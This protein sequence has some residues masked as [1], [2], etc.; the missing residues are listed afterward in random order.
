MEEIH[1]NDNLVLG[2]AVTEAINDLNKEKRELEE[3]IEL[4]KNLEVKSLTEE[5]WHKICETPLRH[6]DVLSVFIQ[7]MFEGATDIQV[8]ANIVRF[9][10]KDFIIDIP[11]SL[12]RGITVD[13]SWYV[14]IDKMEENIEDLK[15]TEW[16]NL[17]IHMSTN[18]R[19]VYQ[20]KEYL[21]KKSEG[22]NW[23]TLFDIIYFNQKEFKLSNLQQRILWWYD[24]KVAPIDDKYWE[25]YIQNYE[26]EVEKSIK[27]QEQRIKECYDKLD[28]FF[29]EIYPKL[30]EFTD[31]IEFR[32]VFYQYRKGLRKQIDNH[33]ISMMKY[34]RSNF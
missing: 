15:N 14:D 8:G 23:K 34:I 9:N 16:R 22:A 19:E 29:Y 11:T 28:K 4:L 32:D 17:D 21:E 30:R 6:N 2:K 31:M 5:E 25:S 3:S 1:M 33:D 26:E 27:T 20:Y 10:Y 18:A 12:C 7:T 24:A 13:M